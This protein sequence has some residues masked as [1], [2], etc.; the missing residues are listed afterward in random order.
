MITHS[1]SFNGRIRR[2]EY[3]LSFIM[4]WIAM[5]IIGSVEKSM[6]FNETMKFFIMIPF[7]W[8]LIAQRTKRCHDRSNGGWFQIIPL[9][10]LWM[11]F[12]DS[13]PGINE[14]GPNPKGL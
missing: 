8:F 13:T 6:S 12:G 5:Y 2:T 14:Y 10:D 3:G 11:L 9:Y 4:F 7:L 1:F